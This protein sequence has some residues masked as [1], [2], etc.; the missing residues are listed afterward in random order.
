[1]KLGP[2]DV[3]SGRRDFLGWWKEQGVQGKP[4]QPHGPPEVS[5]REVP[6]P[7]GGSPSGAG[8]LVGERSNAGSVRGGQVGR[9]TLPRAGFPWLKQT[10]AQPNPRE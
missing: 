8:C 7:Q 6:L 3:H 1:M 10:I 5:H 2:M 9:A 4:T